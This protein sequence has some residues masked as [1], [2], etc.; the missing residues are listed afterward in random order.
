[1]NVCEM[2]AKLRTTYGFLP[3]RIQV[4]DV[5]D[6]GVC[7]RPAVH[8]EVAEVEFDEKADCINLIAYED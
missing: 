1:M 2:V 5:D 6:D 3:V 7:I 4:L 8:Y